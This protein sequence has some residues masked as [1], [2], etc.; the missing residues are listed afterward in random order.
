[1][2]KVGLVLLVLFLGFW[3]LNDPQG[4]ADSSAAAVGAIWG[5]TEQVFTSAMDFFAEVA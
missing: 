2:K 3:L 4:M 1:M 5:L